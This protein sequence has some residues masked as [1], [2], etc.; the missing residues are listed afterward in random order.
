ML[1]SK[2]LADKNG[3]S[4][5]DSITLYSLD[6]RREDTFQVVGIFSGTEGMAK[7]AMMADGIPAN[8]GYIDM[9]SYQKI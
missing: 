4:A 1:I 8:Q 3:L 9:N 5:G 6:S 7:D 2:E